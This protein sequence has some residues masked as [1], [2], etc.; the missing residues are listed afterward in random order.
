MNAPKAVVCDLFGTMVH[1]P[2]PF[3]RR[4]APNVL[5][6]SP[7][8]WLSAVR[9]VALC[10]SFNTAEELAWALSQAAGAVN[11]V[12][13]KLLA[14]MLRRHLERATL[15]AGA[16]SV[17]RFL[18]R[19]G[20][21]LA[22]LSNLSSAHAD[23]VDRLG[24]R[25]LFDV[26]LFS[27]QVGM[28]KP[29][30][31]MAQRLCQELRLSAQEILLVGDSPSADGAF[32]QWG[33]SVLLVGTPELPRFFQLG[34]LG[35][36]GGTVQPLLRLGQE[37]HLGSNPWKVAAMEPLAEGQEGRYNLLAVLRGEGGEP[38]SIYAKRFWEP[39]G[40]L[41]DCLAR[42]FAREL[43]LLTPEAWVL[44]GQ[45]PILLSR[46]AGGTPYRPP[47]DEDVAFDLGAHLAFAYAV[48]NADIRP[49]N[50]FVARQPDGR[51]R[52]VLIDYEHCFF[53]LA[54]P[55]EVVASL[56]SSHRLQRLSL[57]QAQRLAQRQVITPKTI[58]RARNEFFS[59]GQAEPRVRQ[60]LA[61]GFSWC[62]RQMQGR[63]AE[64]VERLRGELVRQPPLRLGT[65]RFRRPL[66]AFDVEEMGSRLQQPL[67]QVLP[68]FL[69]ER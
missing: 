48:A 6:V 17:L 20:I 33:F 26:V 14:E 65:W 23:I 24:L 47:V 41:V 49:R 18:R 2:D 58:V 43:G 22:L 30:A 52:L 37:L 11:P 64:L 12:A 36:E 15:E 67:D 19:R 68:L 5:G 10:R 3:F 31:G 61:E 8:A 25:E 40:A 66:A 60:A 34:W 69:A 29:A 28:A 59:W 35:W 27:C 51:C 50:A 42:S 44:E 62:W 38:D 46:P 7:R 39:T 32:R 1:L 9:R 53:N 54:L 45:E 21:R 4:L 55:P 13:P 63:A 56:E 57:E 16:L